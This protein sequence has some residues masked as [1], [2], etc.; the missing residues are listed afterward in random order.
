MESKA[1]SRVGANLTHA[2]FEECYADGTGVMPC[3]NGFRVRLL[4]NTEFRF[5]TAARSCFVSS[6]GGLPQVCES[7]W[8]IRCYQTLVPNIKRLLHR[9]C[10]S[11]WLC[12][13]NAFHV[14]PLVFAFVWGDCVTCRLQCFGLSQSLKPWRSSFRWALPVSPKEITT[15]STALS[16]FI[17][18]IP[19]AQDS[20]MFLLRSQIS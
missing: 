4:W 11:L 10:F 16:R 12:S 7:S 1:Y 3:R 18:L 8:A 5:R 19:F 2:E 13:C 6:W 15:T 14:L 17:Q 9:C 20:K